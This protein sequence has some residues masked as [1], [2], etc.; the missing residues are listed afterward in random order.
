MPLPIARH[1]I[2]QADL[3]RIVSDPLPWDELFGKTVLISGAN[4]L[5]PS[6]LLETLLYLNETIH[7]G[8]HTIA[9]VRNR[10]RAMRRLGHLVHRPDLTLVVQDVRDP[11]GGPKA[12]DIIIH[13]AGQSSPKFYGTDPVG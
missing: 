2:I 13:A 11:Y 3:G 7:A 1:P 12:V 4:G 6:Y 8:I 10:E 9:L 5:V